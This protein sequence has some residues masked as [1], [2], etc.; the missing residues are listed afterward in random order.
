M[1][2]SVVACVF[3]ALPMSLEL[4]KERHPDAW[5]VLATEALILLAVATRSSLFDVVTAV[6]RLAPWGPRSK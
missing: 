4:L 1:A 3:R 5:K 6:K 2:T